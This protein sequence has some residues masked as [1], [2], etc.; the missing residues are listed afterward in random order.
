MNRRAQLLMPLA[1][2][3]QGGKTF[4]YHDQDI[5]WREG[6]N[7]A[8]RKT[9]LL[10]HGFPSASWDWSAVWPLLETGFRLITLDLIGFGFSAKPRDHDYSIADQASLCE[11]L[12]A[13]LGIGSYHVLAHDYGDSVAQ[14]L[15][16]RARDGGIRPRLESICFLNGGLFPETHRPRMIQRLLS[17]PIGPLVAQMTTR[18]NLAANMLAIAGP[19]YPPGPEV[20]D[21]L[22]AL[23]TRNEGTAVFP[24]LI[25]YMRE[26]RRWRGRWVGALVNATIPLRL[27]DG[28]ADPV[29]GAHM[30]KRYCQLAPNSDC[31]L[32][33]GIGHYPQIEAPQLVADALLNFH[34]TCVT[35]GSSSA[36]IAG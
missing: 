7:P 29:S 33:A 36:S 31:I 34:D 32:L 4:K 9:L 11:A 14:E 23:I 10:I 27:V 26:R 6:G 20:I 5:F 12:M 35:A 18:E 15:L 17:S 30:A 16:A 2:W 24:K 3:E 21:G 25:G 28:A 13:Q 22:W 8:A 1:L 19:D